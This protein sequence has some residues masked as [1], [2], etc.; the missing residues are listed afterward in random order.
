MHDEMLS[1]KY[2][3]K[4]IQT[5]ILGEIQWRTLY[6]WCFISSN[7]L[8]TSAFPDRFTDLVISCLANCVCRMGDENCP[9]DREDQHKIEVL[10]KLADINKALDDEGCDGY[11]GM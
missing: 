11:T 6:C 7:K 4:H 10:V 1:K 5:F 3:F 2:I 9:A 8:I